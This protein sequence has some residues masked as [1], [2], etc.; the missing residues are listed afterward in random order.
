MD[1]PVAQQILPRRQAA[2]QA[3]ANITQQLDDSDS[4]THHAQS[5]PSPKRVIQYG[6]KAMRRRMGREPETIAVPSSLGHDS[7]NLS[8]TPPF[9]DQNGTTIP[10]HDG[11]PKKRPFSQDSTEDALDSPLTPVS[12]SDPLSTSLTPPPTSPFPPSL[13]SRQFPLADQTEGRTDNYRSTRNKRK[14]QG[15][16]SRP[17]KWKKKELGEIVWVLIDDHSRI[18]DHG[19]AAQERE[20]VWWPAKIRTGPPGGGKHLTAFLYGQTASKVKDIQVSYPTEDNILPFND[21]TGEA[22]FREPTFVTPSH[23]NLSNVMSPRKKA[24]RDR[25]ELVNLW[26]AAVHELNVERAGRD[27]ESQ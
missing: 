19:K 15:M 16:V 6:R 26:N 27:A 3:S 8:N 18:F 13:T 1:V 14:R 17:K 24:K 25:S 22:K 23:H 5:S 9:F 21:S 2:K 20:H 10:L 11:R 12:D 7:Q 4:D